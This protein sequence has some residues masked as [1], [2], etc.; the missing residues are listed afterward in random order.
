MYF[1]LF[2]LFVDELSTW[3]I[4]SINMF[5]DD[6][7]IWCRISTREDSLGQQEDLN[8]LISWSQTWLLRFH[9]EKCKVM[10]IGHQIST[11]YKMEDSGNTVQ[12][13]TI[14]EE[15]DLHCSQFLAR[16]P[17][18]FAVCVVQEFGLFVYITLAVQILRCLFACYLYVC[19]CIINKEVHSDMR[20]S[21][22]LTDCRLS[23]NETF[24]LLKSDELRGIGH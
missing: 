2:L 23:E 20:P 24:Q 6:T 3:I 8:K 22:I 19:H 12:L 21:Q 1:S 13:M 10:H 15:K 11:E 16:V 18:P 5:A 4:N 9:P 7:K 14:K 17:V